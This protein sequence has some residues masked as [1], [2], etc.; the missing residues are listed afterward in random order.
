[1]MIALESL[2]WEFCEP[3]RLRDHDQS[4]DYLR[5][6]HPKRPRKMTTRNPFPMK[7]T[8]VTRRKISIRSVLTSPKRWPPLPTCQQ[9]KS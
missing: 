2:G 4:D 8:T 3:A 5:T 1:M 9:E 6:G 7:K